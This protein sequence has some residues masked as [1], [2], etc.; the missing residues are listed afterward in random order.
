M[1]KK[2]IL[3]KTVI[4]QL[5]NPNRVFGGEGQLPNDFSDKGGATC[6]TCNVGATCAG[7]KTCYSFADPCEAYITCGPPING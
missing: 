2:L 6:Q 7:D 4:A 5:T 1:N 3:N